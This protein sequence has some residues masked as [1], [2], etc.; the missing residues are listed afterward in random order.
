MPSTQRGSVV[1]RGNR[2]AA[3]WYDERSVRRFQGGFETK[4]EARTFV[5]NKVDEVAAL[6]R[7]DL[8]RPSEIPTVT[9]LIDGFL[10]THDVDPATTD[11]LRYEL[12]H[13]RHEFGNLRIDQL[14]PLELSRWRATLPPRSRHQPFGAFK[15]VLEEAVTLGLLEAN[16]CAR[17][18][19][20]RT[21][22]DEDREIR[23]FASWD[24]LEAIA[25]ELH[26]RY[27][28]VPIVLAGTG[29]RPEELW[30]LERRDLDR[31][32]GVLNIERVFTQNRLK[33]C[34]KSD[35]QRRRVPLRAKVLEAIDA[36][37]RPQRFDG[38]L[39]GNHEGE[40]TRH[41]TFRLRHWTPA[42]RAAGIEHRSVYACRH[43]F[44]SWAI[45]AG[46][47]LFYL[48][49]VMGTSVAMIGATYGHLVPD[50]DDYLRRLLDSYDLGMQSV[51]A[52]GHEA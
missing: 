3:R 24:E 52:G 44:A 4:S 50:S 14:K 34:K 35:L 29:L 16:P 6:R 37:P 49:R 36:M 33:P 11:K 41:A 43:T 42:L 28:A 39:F 7:G 22:L 21:K 15:Q 23:P 1:K 5:D 17:I 47:Q 32:N 20:R 38:P 51:S 25:E 10:A 19:N 26:P 31:T 27:R 8:P 40:R 13:A 48:S 12:A 46:V 9:V 18:R 45:R 2:W 30:G